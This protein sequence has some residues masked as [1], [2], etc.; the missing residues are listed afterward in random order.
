MTRSGTVAF[1]ASEVTYFDWEGLWAKVVRAPG[2]GIR[3]FFMPVDG[4]DWV[5]ASPSDISREG[6]VLFETGLDEDP[7]AAFSDS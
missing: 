1:M 6:K 5:P 4:T 7:P 2:D 3:G